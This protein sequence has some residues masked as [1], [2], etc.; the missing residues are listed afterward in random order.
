LV[1]YVNVSNEYP[2][3]S[4]NL[5]FEWKNSFIWWFHQQHEDEVYLLPKEWQP[6]VIWI[7]ISNF[8]F[9]SIDASNHWINLRH[10]KLD[11]EE[12]DLDTFLGLLYDDMESKVINHHS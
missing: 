2:R 10:S 4:M 8:V 11:A 1:D 3:Q 7:R 6:E 5:S 9:V 12:Y